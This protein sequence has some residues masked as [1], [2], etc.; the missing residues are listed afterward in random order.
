MKR[1]RAVRVVVLGVL[2]GCA[3]ASGANELC[4]AAGAAILAEIGEFV[5]SLP[6]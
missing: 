4:F 3:L 2:A 5:W 1:S 6:S